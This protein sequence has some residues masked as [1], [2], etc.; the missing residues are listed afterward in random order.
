MRPTYS[1]LLVLVGLFFSSSAFA[2]EFWIPLTPIKGIDDLP[3][4]SNPQVLPGDTLIYATNAEG[5]FR[6]SNKGQSWNV[7]SPYLREQ[8]I[9]IKR[10]IKTKTGLWVA[11]MLGLDGTIYSSDNGVSWQ[12]SDGL[13]FYLVQNM[14]EHPEGAL[15]ASVRQLGVVRSVDYGKSWSAMNSGLPEGHWG[16][17]L[18]ALHNGDLIVGTGFNNTYGV[19][20]SSNK[21]LSWTA[22]PS[23]TASLVI[24]L[25]QDQIARVFAGTSDRGVYRSTDNGVTWDPTDTSGIGFANVE[26]IA[27]G[28][29]T[30]IFISTEGRGVFR[31]FDGNSWAYT[32]AGSGG[33][34]NRIAVA[35]DGIVYAG[36]PENMVR[37]AA[38]TGSI[39]PTSG[40][41]KHEDPR[42]LRISL[43]GARTLLEVKNITDMT[44]YKIVDILG[45][46]ILSGRMISNAIEI[47]SLP[48]GLYLLSIG[49]HS[50]S[51]IK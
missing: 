24:S 46:T 35:M 2:Q 23:L 50:A 16:E 14:V 10:V 5:I 13:P 29:D 12:T 34:I 39:I 38:S 45:R 30:S 25:A 11:S 22:V 40:G 36:I 15:F 21:G 37:S 27:I 1:A 49:R 26:S 51:F 47:S 43:N 20:R 9:G 44:G 32:G 19:Y 6:S 7:V 28:N 41:V 18:V 3:L 33:S 48:G 31:S 17:G 42:A 4:T 8:G